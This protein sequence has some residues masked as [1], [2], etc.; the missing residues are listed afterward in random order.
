MQTYQQATEALHAFLAKFNKGVDV[1]PDLDL[2]E[3]RVVTSLRFLHFIMLIEE[4]SGV[5]I[6]PGEIDIA[7]LKSVSAIQAHFLS[8]LPDAAVGAE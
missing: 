8:S 4:L 2:F 6:D 3:A 7:Q 5:E 1:E